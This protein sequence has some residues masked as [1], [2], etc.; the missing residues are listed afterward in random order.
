MD[1]K[2]INGYK[3]SKWILAPLG[4]CCELGIKDFFDLVL[5]KKKQKKKFQNIQ[6]VSFFPKEYVRIQVTFILLS[7]KVMYSKASY[8]TTS[9][10]TDLVIARFWIGSKITQT[11]R[12]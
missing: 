1:L 7:L 3:G 11:A 10:S 5:F 9:N 4:S 6:G 8:S 2:D 12:F